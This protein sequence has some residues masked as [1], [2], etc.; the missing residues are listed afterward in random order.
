[1]GHHIVGVLF[2]GPADVGAAEAID[3][4]AVALVDDWWLLWMDGIYS[5][6]WQ[7]RLGTEGFLGLPPRVSREAAAGLPRERVLLE[8]VARVAGRPSPPFAAVYTDYFGGLGSQV[9]VA[10]RDGAP[11]DTDGTINDALRALGVVAKPG[12]D[13]FD[14]LELGRYRGI[15]EPL[16]DRWAAYAND[17][18]D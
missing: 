10:Y 11:L 4:A 16:L 5:E 14:T 8:L 7:E 9:A 2:R 18:G 12:L 15:P 3:S 6:S 17:Q 1:M 13:E